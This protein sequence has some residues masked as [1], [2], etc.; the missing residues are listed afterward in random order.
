MW[1]LALALLAAPSAD[2]A[3]R[4]G[5]RVQPLDVT[6]VFDS[7]GSMG[8]P[9]GA[10]KQHIQ[11]MIVVLRK[12]VPAL[13][14]GMVTYRDFADAYDHKSIALTDDTARVVAWLNRVSC[15]GGGDMP[16]AVHLGLGVAVEEFSW[17]EDARK[18]VI[19]I[20]DAPPHG[21]QLQTCYDLARGAYEKDIIVHTIT[22]GHRDALRSFKRIAELAGGRSV[23]LGE[24]SLIGHLMNL[25]L[26]YSLTDVELRRITRH[27][28]EEPEEKPEA[29]VPAGR[30]KFARLIHDGDWDVP[31][32]WR[33][34]LA[35]L[36]KRHH[37][38]FHGAPVNV[39]ADDEALFDSPFLYITG[40]HAMKLTA[41]QRRRL[42]EYVQAGGFIMA[43]ACCGRKAFDEDFRAL[44]RELFP[45]S[46]LQRLPSDHAIY[47]R[48]YRIE[49]VQLSHP[50]GTGS[51]IRTAP[52]LEA[53]HLDGRLAVVYSRDDLGCG[54]AAGPGITCGVAEGDAYALTVNI[55]MRALG[56]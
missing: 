39:A 28:D 12:R 53:I 27:R 48:P 56:R 41:P 44:M 55:L 24:S 17:K 34:L 5:L 6:F 37:L 15:S 19:L 54:W 23:V 45:H 36:R 40:H 43:E 14:V 38:D 18:V 20:G 47:Q 35:S 42:R 52:R 1:A 26:G 13:R 2:A 46:P 4:C 3:C 50:P 29:E 9:I 8:G 51:L 31:H 7:T 16:E 33:G 22:T 11:G 10:V 30:L 32:A 49:T 25:S 21:N